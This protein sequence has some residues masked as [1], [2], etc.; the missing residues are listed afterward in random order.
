[1]EERPT[2]AV[3]AATFAENATSEAFENTLRLN[4]EEKSRVSFVTD[5]KAEA[6]ED[7]IDIGA[8]SE[9]AGASRG[10]RDGVRAKVGKSIGMA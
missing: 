1:M 10:V 9:T 3:R 8:E 4:K 7:P 5:T 6:D 2:A